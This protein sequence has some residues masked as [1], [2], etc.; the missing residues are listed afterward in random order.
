VTP[1]A[2]PYAGRY[3]FLP[4]RRGVW[5]AIVEFVARDIGP[6]ESLLELGPGYCDFV[7][8]FPAATRIAIDITPE[9]RAFAAPGVDFRVGDAAELAGIPAQSVDLVFASHFLEHLTPERAGRLLGRIGRVLRPGGRVALLQPN[10]RLCPTRY[11]DDPTH[12]TA[13]SDTDLANLL[14]AA[15]F[16]PLRIV[17]G[18]LPFSMRSALPKW[19]PLVRAYLALPL[20]PFAAQM[21]L[22]ATP[23]VEPGAVGPEGGG[24]HLEG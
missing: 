12:L 17:P 22:V 13:Y 3:R 6:V 23:A 15:G 16:R 18:L 11:F 20:R 9:M 4:R 24:R 7:N 8:Q 21:Y 5:R 14:L 10:F 2:N 19:Y 1:A